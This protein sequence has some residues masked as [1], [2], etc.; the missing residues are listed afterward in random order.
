MKVRA[1]R[2]KRRSEGGMT[3]IELL[4]VCS[5]LSIVGT[6]IMVAFSVGLVAF[7]RGGVTDRTTAANDLMVF[8]Q[9]LGKDVARAVCIEAPTTSSTTYGRC[10]NSLS[11]VSTPCVSSGSTKSLLCIAW[12]Q[13]PPFPG[14]PVCHTA[15]Y[16]PQGSVITRQETWLGGSGQT[17]ISLDPVNVNAVSLVLPSYP[18]QVSPSWI[19]QV[20]VSNV[21]SAIAKLL[22][23]P[24][25]NFQLQPLT[26]NP[27]AATVP[28]VC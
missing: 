10:A 26:V 1:Y 15:V 3:L 6:V 23:P 7:G 20:K 18:T 11:S 27:A 28:A 21:R 9:R 25:G 4:V 17:H 8:E 13:L 5:I 14:L 16:S 22:N 2:T 24:I 19:A 12:P